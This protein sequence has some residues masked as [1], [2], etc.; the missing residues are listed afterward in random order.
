MGFKKILSLAL[1]AVICLGICPTLASAES[2][3]ASVAEVDYAFDENDIVFTFANLSDPHVGFGSNDEILRTSLATIK[4]YASHGIDAVLFNGDQTQDGKKEQAQLFVSIVK[5][6]FDVTK[7]PVILTHGNHDVYWSGCMSRAEFVEAYGSDMYLFDVDAESIYSGN[8]HVEV[9]GYH[10]VSV[11]IQTYMP[12]QNTLSSATQAWLKETLDS[13]VAK[14]PESYIFVSCHSPAKD[15]VYGSMSDDEKGTGDWGAS[16]QLDSILK[17]YPQVILFSGHTHYAINLES[18]INQT[19]YTQINSGSSSDIDFDIT[20]LENRRSYSQGMIVE[21]DGGGNI[22]ITRIDLAKDCVIKTPWYI[23]AYKPDG[24]SLTRYSSAR[25]DA[26][27]A[28]SFS[29]GLEV[30]EVSPTELKINFEAAVDDDMVYYYEVEVDDA[31]GKAI[32]SKRIMT[33]F[34][35]YPSLENMPKSYSATFSGSYGYPYTVKVRAYD[36]F[37]KYGELSQ[38]FEDLS[39]QNAASAREFDAR[40]EELMSRELTADDLELMI[41]VHKDVGKLNYKVKELMER[42]GELE[43][44]ERDYFNRYFLTDCAD[45]F[46]PNVNSTFSTAPMTSSGWVEQSEGVGVS[47]NWKNATKNYFLGF[48]SK[49]DLDGLHIGFTGLTAE[50]ESKS[51]GIMLSNKYKTKWTSD[52]GLV[53][54]I[55][56]ASGNVSTGS[57]VNIGRSEL[58]EYDNVASIPF[59][60][61]FKLEASGGVLMSISSALGNDTLTIPAT[62]LGGISGLSDTSA[63]YVSLSPWSTR[64]TMSVDVCA[65]HTEE[66]AEPVIPIEPDEPTVPDEPIGD[67]DGEELGFFE[68]IAAFFRGIFEAIGRFFTELFGG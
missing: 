9:G 13:I 19:T 60:I 16:V 37:G 27:T 56:F 33:P 26:N 11:D 63:C 54:N 58:L 20:T 65:I 50:S 24:S 28:P 44:L 4:K 29:S 35:D 21:V 17:D 25:L 51:L 2:G 3:V 47:L 7:T 36:C 22:R 42:L 18:N 5:E 34:Y 14:D 30:V 59:D 23:D 41:S 32:F 45:D 66:R 55:D 53:I 52:E 12:N 61:R 64:T 40:I 1:V 10:F 46:S 48:G 49:L 62:A 43:A 39:E 68:S 15:T 38:V 67:N 8:R 6:A 57:G 31:S